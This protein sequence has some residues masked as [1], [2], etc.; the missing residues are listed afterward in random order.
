MM[1]TPTVKHSPAQAS[2]AVAQ[3]PVLQALPPARLLDVWEAGEGQP[4][5][6]RALSL[7]AAAY[8]AVD[9][10]GLLAWSVG[11]RDLYVLALRAACFGRDV[12][13]VA[14]CPVCGE[15]LEIAFDVAD[16]VAPVT[17][18]IPAPEDPIMDGGAPQVTADWNGRA[19]RFRLPNAGDLVALSH[20]R[21][22]DEG[23]RLL[24]HRCSLDANGAEV[25]GLPEPVVEALAQRMADADPQADVRLALTCPLCDHAWMATFD[26]TAHLWAEVDAWARRTLLEVHTLARAYGWCEAE[27]LALSPQRRQRYLELIASTDGGV[28]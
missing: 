15:R 2:P 7:L 14:D 27:I 18:Q 13:S 20:C 3:L 6:W 12:E 5:A 21:D 19:L 4:L 8:P 1:A 26:I 23:R 11:R 17:E 10:E 25:D 24:L 22:L 28:I 9:R 16:I